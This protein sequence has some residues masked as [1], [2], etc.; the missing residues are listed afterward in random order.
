MCYNG[1][2]HESEQFG[3]SN[4]VQQVIIRHK[5]WVAEHRLLTQ[6]TKQKLHIPARRQV[7]QHTAH[8]DV[9]IPRDAEALFEGE[10]EKVAMVVHGTD[11]DT[12]AA[13]DTFIGETGDVWSNIV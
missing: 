1:S 2:W 8:I 5:L 9:A 3:G 13:H 11:G 10:H 6:A 4:K 7:V 12:G